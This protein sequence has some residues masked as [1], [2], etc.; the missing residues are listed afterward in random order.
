MTD[1]Y[2]LLTRP[3][4]AAPEPGPD[5]DAEVDVYNDQ[6][7]DLRRIAFRDWPGFRDRGYR[8]IA[9]K[10][11]PEDLPRAPEPKPGLA[12]A[13]PEVGDVQIIQRAEARR[14]L[15]EAAT[16]LA[17]FVLAEP[18]QWEQFTRGERQGVLE[19]YSAAIVGQAAL[20]LTEELASLREEVAALKAAGNG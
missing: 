11:Q 1:V 7:R 20:K 10:E 6:S 19:T 17:P 5:P 18:L 2:S 4:R 12:L 14:A 16:A 3:R 9:G 13:R 15:H 8:Q